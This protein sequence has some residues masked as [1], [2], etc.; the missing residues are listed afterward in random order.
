[1]STVEIEKLSLTEKLGMMEALWESL[2]KNE[3]DIPVPSWHV[4][5]LEQTQ[6]RRD[7][8]E[9]KLVDWKEAKAQLRNRFQ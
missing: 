9:E 7:S 8:G 6:Q 1:M 3:E 4:E 2:S 5:A